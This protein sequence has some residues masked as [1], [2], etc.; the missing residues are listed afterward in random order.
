MTIGFFAS[1]NAFAVASISS[2]FGRIST[3][4]VNRLCGY[5]RCVTLRAPSTLDGSRTCTG[6]PGGVPASLNARRDISLMWS[7][8]SICQRAFVNWII[9]STQSSI[10]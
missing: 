9:G 3:G 2:G 4:T 6:P 10:C 8:L 5:T 1:S 7:A